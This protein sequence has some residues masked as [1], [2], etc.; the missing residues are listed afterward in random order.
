MKQIRAD[1]LESLS[2]E[3]NEITAHPNYRNIIIEMFP[4]LKTLDSKAITTIERSTIEVGKHLT[5]LYLVTMV[6]LE[7]YTDKLSKE[8]VRLNIK[9]ELYQRAYG[10]H[11]IFCRNEPP[12]EESVIAKY[13]SLKNCIIEEYLYNF[14]RKDLRPAN[15]IALISSVLRSEILDFEQD[16]AFKQLVEKRLMVCMLNSFSFSTHSYF[17]E[18]NIFHVF[19]KETTMCSFFTRRR[20]VC[21]LRVGY[22]ICTNFVRK[23]Y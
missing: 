23:V 15:L 5:N 19:E 22:C 8:N 16:F 21:C 3:G 20:E 17:I 14:D 11:S 6:N 9:L 2:L 12:M 18:R 13:K 4:S 7:Y 10:T 1:K